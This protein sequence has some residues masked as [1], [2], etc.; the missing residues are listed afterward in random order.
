MRATATM[1]TDSTGAR[2]HAPVSE[3]WAA[4]FA[5]VAPAR[6]FPSFRGQVNFTGL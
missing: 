6:S 5:R 3:V 2:R 1:I 4:P